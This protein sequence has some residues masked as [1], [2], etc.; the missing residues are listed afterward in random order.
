MKWAKIYNDGHMWAKMGNFS[1]I[2][3]PGGRIFFILSYFLK[4]FHLV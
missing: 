1:G 2:S 4:K 3:D